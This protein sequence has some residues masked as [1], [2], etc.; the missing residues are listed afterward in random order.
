MS[1]IYN[2]FRRIRIS[3]GITVCNEVHELRLLMDTLLPIVDKRDEIILLQ[4]ITLEDEE[5]TS[6]ISSYGNKIK[7]IK[8]KLNG[9]FSTFKNKLISASSGDYLFQIDADEL[10]KPSLIKGIKQVLR[11]K[12]KADCFL[13]PRINIVEGLTADHIKNW[14]WTVDAQNRANYP[15]HQFRIFKL[16]GRIKWRNK[17]HEE[18]EGFTRSYH[19]PSET[20][21]W[22]LVHVK[23]IGKQV[24]QDQLYSKIISQ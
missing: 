9:D 14:N 7:H 20:E 17:I 21:E 6:L 15:D 1:I 13:V 11:K 2:I 24:A 5:V 18:L 19:L 10:P 23:S 3:Y 16:D 8:A 12:Y 22:C 4:D